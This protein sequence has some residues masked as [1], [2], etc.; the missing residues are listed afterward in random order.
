MKLLGYEFS[1]KREQRSSPEN[2]R[3]SLSDPGILNAL[4]I[5]DDSS[6]RVGP[7]TALQSSAVFACVRVLAEGVA[8]L[9]LHLYRKNDNGQREKLPDHPIA[10]LLSHSPNGGMNRVAYF[11]QQTSQLALW[12]NCYAQRVFDRR[13]GETKR[14]FPLASVNCSVQMKSMMSAD[15]YPDVMKMFRVGT[16]EFGPDDIVHIPLM[17]MDGVAG[18]SPIT[19]N[20]MGIALSLSQQKFSERLYANGVRL[21]GVLEHP[22]KLSPEAGSRLRENFSSVYAGTNNAGKAAILEEGMKFSPIAMPLED[23]QFIETIKFSREQIASIFRVPPHMIGHLD[24][25][26]F[27]NIEHQSLEFAVY[28]LGPYLVKFEQAFNALLSESERETHY[29]RFNMDALLRGDIKSRYE[30]YKI[31]R[32]WG[33]LSANDILELED[34]NPIENGNVYLQPMN[35]QAPGTTTGTP[36]GDPSGP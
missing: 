26:T 32:E 23:A 21:S 14:L 20:R 11:E 25:A 31:A 15:G 19:L 22:G 12:G 17:S 28:T 10:K 6:E 16:T 29:F 34:R 36:G 13:T 24:R 35:M 18:L 8:Q 5:G 1:V 4:G 27:S 9:P 3:Y 33:W 30:A 7:Q 2:P